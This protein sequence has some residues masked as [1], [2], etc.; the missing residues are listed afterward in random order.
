MTS[1][2]IHP[3]LE[4]ILPALQPEELQALEQS[5]ITE[6]IREAIY[7][8]QGY[9]IDGHNRYH[10]AQIHK[11]KFESRELSF[12]SLRD[13]KIWMI[14]N[15]CSRR[16]I[17]DFV[18]FELI[19]KKRELLELK[20]KESQ[21]RRTD[22]LSQSDKKLNGHNTQQILAGELG[23][24]TGKLAK[25]E[26]VFK[27]TTKDVKDQLRRNETTISKVYA[28]LRKEQ[29]KA[30]QQEIQRKRKSTPPL[31]GEYDLIYCDP[32]WRYEHPTSLST[33]IE[34]HYPTMLL[35]EIK[36]LKIPSAENCLLFMWSTAPKLDEALGVMH[37]WQFNY[38]TCAVWDKQSIGLGYWFRGQ[39]ELLLV[40][41][42][43]KV[44]TPDSKNRF[45]SVIRQKRGRH[46]E[47]P[48]CVYDMLN[49][50]YPHF[51]KIELFA[52]NTAEGFDNWGNEELL[53][54]GNC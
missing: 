47:K 39:H 32:P 2:I 17:S 18:R 51:H 16:S 45:A 27:K 36:A 40:G 22:L 38:R 35:D 12:S 52:R 29:Q 41:M 9:I 23:W 53:D 3:E 4:L 7:T 49:T 10:I 48:K 25:A 6:G 44:M 8:W 46:S 43:G 19:R 24:S 50:M 33:A 5:C 1:L 31:R 14:E 13:A 26:V 42:K 21:G 20:G 28:D 37:A 11:L 34:S 54:K 30:H 15:Q